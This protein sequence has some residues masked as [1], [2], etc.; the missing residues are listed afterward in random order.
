MQEQFRRKILEA[1]EMHTSLE[2]LKFLNARMIE[3]LAATDFRL[4]FRTMQRLSKQAESFSQL[5]ADDLDESEDTSL[6]KVYIEFTAL[7]EHGVFLQYRFTSGRG[8]QGVYR[9]HISD[10]TQPLTEKMTRTFTE[11]YRFFL[12]SISINFVSSE[13]YASLL[14]HLMAA[15][16][17]EK[18]LFVYCF[19]DNSESPLEALIRHCRHYQL[20]ITAAAGQM[21]PNLEIHVYRI[22]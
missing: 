13:V 19:K 12:Y 14:K 9:R 11:G 7:D 2:W 20:Q 1:K 5:D 8:F 4:T 21:Y 16:P 10:L 3:T 17:A 15:I 6:P 22:N 18:F